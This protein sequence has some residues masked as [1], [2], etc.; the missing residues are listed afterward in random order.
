MAT[1]DTSTGTYLTNLFNP[2]VVGDMINKKLVD[3]IR[4]APLAR[5][6]DNLVGRPGNTI[7][8]PYYNFVGAAE[9]TLEG[10]DVPIKQLTEQTA[11]V[12]IKKYGLGVQ[13]TDEAMLSGYGNPADEAVRQI[14]LA[15]ASAVDN[16]L[17]AVMATGAAAGMTT[18]AGAFTANG[19]IEA[20]TLFGEDIDGEK[21][22]LINPAAYEVIRKAT[23]YI[24]GTD[25]AA[26]I[27]IRG[28]VGYFHGCQVVVSNKLTSANCAYIVKPGALAI[29]R[30]RDIFVET[31]RDIINKS[32]V[33]T[34]DTHFATYVLDPSRL[35][36]MP[37]AGSST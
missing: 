21:A 5:V 19:V 1:V 10:H 26:N 23:G 14:T 13:L 25:V 35:I 8:L 34:A 4:F 15:L 11:E 7:S 27:I 17:L 30:K 9:L 18:D 6:Y 37:G 22:L 24:S 2:Q 12:T 3:A 16:D 20:L 36:K 33:I 31:D 29:Y 28:T 32:T